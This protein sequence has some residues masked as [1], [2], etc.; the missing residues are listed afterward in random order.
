MT[1]AQSLAAQIRKIVRSDLRGA[2]LES[3][4]LSL[5]L[6][7]P[8]SLLCQVAGADS[9]GRIRCSLCRLSGGEQAG[10]MRFIE[11]I[12]AALAQRMSPRAKI[13]LEAL[14]EQLDSLDAN[15][16]LLPSGRPD[17]NS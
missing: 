10:C 3:A 8:E 6:E 1:P 17:Q 12:L 15:D 4:V 2:L 5:S 7:D 11:P 13:R 16:A 9:T 14:A